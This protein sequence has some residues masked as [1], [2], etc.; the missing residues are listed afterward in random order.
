MMTMFSK[1]KINTSLIERVLLR[2]K[3]NSFHKSKNLSKDEILKA[4][5]LFCGSHIRDR[6]TQPDGREISTFIWRS[7]MSSERE[8]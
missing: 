7:V 5:G 6:T 2:I 3:V 8:A 4:C 1:V